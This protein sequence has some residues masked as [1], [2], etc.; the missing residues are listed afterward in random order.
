M[1]YIMMMEIFSVALLQGLQIKYLRVL[2]S[3]RNSLRH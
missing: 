1:I 3:I 2:I